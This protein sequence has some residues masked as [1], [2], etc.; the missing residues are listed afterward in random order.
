MWIFRFI[1][2]PGIGGI[3]NGWRALA[4]VGSEIQT[5]FIDKKGIFGAKMLDG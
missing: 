1:Q 5:Q 4:A 3:I 2:Q